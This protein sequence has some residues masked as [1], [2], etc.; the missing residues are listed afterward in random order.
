VT[1][2]LPEWLHR[3]LKARYWRILDEA[4]SAVEARA[5]LLALAADDRAAIPRRPR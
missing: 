2:K 5:G 1:K 4:G 3:E